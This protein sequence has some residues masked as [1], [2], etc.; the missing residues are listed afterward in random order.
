[1]ANIL[2]KRGPHANLPSGTS[3]VDGAFYL[4]TDSHRLYAGINNNLVDLNQY[5]QVVANVDA[6]EALT[7]VEPGDFAYVTAG[8]ILAIYESTAEGNKWVQI[9]KQATQITNKSLTAAA[10]KTSDDNLALKINVTDTNGDAVE[11]TVNLIGQNMHI[12]V[13]GDNITFTGK[14]YALSGTVADNALTLTLTDSDNATSEVALTGGQNV[15]IAN[16][17]G[18]F[19]ISS[20]N[21]TL[22]G[23]EN[24]SSITVDN[25]GTVSVT[26]GDSDGNSQT[27][28]A[29]NAIYYTVGKNGTT[30]VYNQGDLNVYTIEEVD[31]KFKTLNPM[32][33]KGTVSSI[34]ELNSKTQISSGDTYMAA[35]S[36]DITSDYIES[37][38]VTSCK[39]GDLF[40][41][42]GDEGENGYIATDDLT[43]T[44]V[45]AGDDS[46][47]DTTY[48]GKANAAGNSLTI[49]DSNTNAVAKVALS[50]SD[51]ITVSSVAD[52]NGKTLT[53]TIAHAD[54]GAADATKQTTGTAITLDDATAQKVIT[55]VSVDSTGHVIGVT[56]SDAKVIGYDLQEATVTLADNVAT[57]KNALKD[58]NSNDCGTSTVKLDASAEDSLKIAVD[59]N[60]IS[61]SLE[62]GTF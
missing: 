44:Y 24:G 40:I 58:D 23:T 34:T 49:E 14:T 8:N 32:S 59:G 5:I 7:N 11:D 9:N 2:F 46:Q 60:T 25:S 29:E 4:T 35:A 36:F 41:A 54:P 31:E 13:D 57:I 27:V 10:T 21:T 3:V 15:T 48:V 50:G 26:I 51:K 45:P 1:M 53:T 33:Y 62:W 18:K 47:T 56:T 12:A 39:I 22:S 16:T 52:D 19:V 17:D 42:V 38:S 55:G 43:W 37:G 20:H 30:S 28:T 61:L 6:L